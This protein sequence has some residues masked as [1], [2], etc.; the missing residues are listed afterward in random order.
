[1]GE[2]RATSMVGMT[3]GARKRGIAWEVKANLDAS[4][5]DTRTDNHRRRLVGIFRGL[6]RIGERLRPC[7]GCTP[8]GLALLRYR[9]V[10]C[11]KCKARGVRLWRPHGNFYRSGDNL[12]TECAPVIDV[13]TGRP[14]WH[15]QLIIGAA[16]EIWGHFADAPEDWAIFERL[17]ISPTILPWAEVCSCSGIIPSGPSSQRKSARMKEA[18]R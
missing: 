8:R 5:S 3:M 16:G 11:A 4:P 12:C 1:M 13:E 14:P 15:V 18:R 10:R 17:P 9:E 7:P 2:F 6:Y